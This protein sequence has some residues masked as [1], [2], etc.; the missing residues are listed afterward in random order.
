MG[1]VEADLFLWDWLNQKNKIRPMSA[2]NP[3]NSIFPSFH[4]SLG[5]LPANR[6]SGVRSKPGSPG[7]NSLPALPQ[8]AFVADAGGEAD[9]IQIVEYRC[10]AP[11]SVAEDFGAVFEGDATFFG[12][13]FFDPHFYLFQGFG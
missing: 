6:S 12:D 13:R 3:Q 2:F 4:Y 10:A 9:F 7:Q 1:L 11:A 8:H 5:Y